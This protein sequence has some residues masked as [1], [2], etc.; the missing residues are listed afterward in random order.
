MLVTTCFLLLA[1]ASIFAISHKSLDDFGTGVQRA[2]AFG[3]VPL[4]LG[5]VSIS[6]FMRDNVYQAEKITRVFW[7]LKSRTAAPTVGWVGPRCG[8]LVPQ[9]PN[10]TGA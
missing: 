7:S 9:Y 8:M 2:L 3:N 4:N 1:S 5:S 6:R 10:G